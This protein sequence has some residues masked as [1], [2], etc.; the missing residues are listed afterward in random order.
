MKS[1]RYLGLL[2][3]FAATAG[4]SAVGNTSNSDSGAKTSTSRSGPAAA[5]VEGRVLDYGRP[6]KAPMSLVIQ[7]RSGRVAAVLSSSATAEVHATKTVADGDP[8][9]QRV[10][11]RERADA[12]VV[13]VLDATER[14]DACGAERERGHRRERDR[15]D[16]DSDHI[17][18]DFEVE[19]PAGVAL[20]ASTLHGDLEARDLQSDVEASTSNGALRLATT[21]RIVASTLNGIIEA[22]ALGPGQADPIDLQSTNGR[23]DVRLADRSSFDIDAST[24]RGSVK[25]DFPLPKV[26]ASFGPSVVRGTVGGG[27]AA[28]RMRTD[29]GDI[30]VRR[31]D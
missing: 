4:C 16:G 18:I 1:S 28:L 24:Q 11:L 25:S 13:C 30:E 20:E 31:V 21:G 19:V 8:A 3:V 26:G 10:V 7:A 23:I 6:M 15:A 9:S 2:A 27:G 12:T 29:S 17:R 5:S 14:D 22:T